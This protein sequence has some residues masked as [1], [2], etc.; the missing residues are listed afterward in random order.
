MQKKNESKTKRKQFISIC[1]V[2]SAHRHW[3]RVTIELYGHKTFDLFTIVRQQNCALSSHH[4]HPEHTFLNVHGTSHKKIFTHT[5]RNE[6]LPVSTPPPHYNVYVF[7]NG[8]K[9]SNERS[10]KNT[11]TP[12]TTTTKNSDAKNLK[13]MVF[14]ISLT[15]SSSIFVLVP[16]S[17]FSPH[18]IANT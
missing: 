14:L 6:I 11:A 18:S 17:S 7:V 1:C 13:W 15:V 3:K 10:R 9:E 16:R 12:E 5:A 2:H 4:N 8:S